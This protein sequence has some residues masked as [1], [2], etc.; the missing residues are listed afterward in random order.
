MSDLTHDIRTRDKR[1]SACIG[2]AV[3]TTLSAIPSLRV[4][5]IRFCRATPGRQV[6]LEKRSP[7][8]RRIDGY[9]ASGALRRLEEFGVVLEHSQEASTLANQSDEQRIK[10]LKDLEAN[11]FRQ[12]LAHPEIQLNVRYSICQ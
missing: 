9:L 4:L 2:D 3:S 12:T 6:T 10:S 1:L 8:W 5:T 7:D 11:L